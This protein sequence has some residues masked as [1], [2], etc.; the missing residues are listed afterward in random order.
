MTIPQQTFAVTGASGG[1]GG[2]VARLLAD[3]GAQ[4]VLVVRNP[5]RAPLIAAAGVRVADYDDPQ[6][7]LTALEG[8]TTLFLISA[9]EHPERVRQHR[10]AVDAAVAAGVTRVVYLSFVGAAPDATFT[11]A[12]DHWATEQ[13][14]RGTDLATTFLRDNMYADFVPY[15]AG[16]DGVMRGPAG[17][18]VVAAVARDDVAD[19]AARVLLEPERHDG[20]TYDLTGPRAFSLHDAAELLS[21]VS[22]RPVTYHPETEEEAYASRAGTGRDFEIAGW[23]SSYQAIATGELSQVSDAVPDI[24]GSP[25]MGLRD[26]LR[27]HPETWAHLLP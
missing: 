23:V 26:V 1:V 18:G 10:Q 6:G 27:R 19:V 24:T 15:F 16:T 4:Q 17:D 12:R 7:M 20:R 13:Y 14:L 11:F 25:A 3:A 5:A 21:E 9:S 22:G 8:V 2:R